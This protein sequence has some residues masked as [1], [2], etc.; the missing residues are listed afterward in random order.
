MPLPVL[1]TTPVRAMNSVGFRKIEP[2]ALTETAISLRKTP[3]H[4]AMHIRFTL[5]GHPRPFIL[6]ASMSETEEVNK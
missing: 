3:I 5:S 6:T 2:K 4:S 1:H